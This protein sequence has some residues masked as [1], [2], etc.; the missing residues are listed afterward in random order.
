MTQSKVG[1]ERTHIDARFSGKKKIKEL[2]IDTQRNFILL[3]NLSYIS[4]LSSL[5]FSNVVL[6]FETIEKVPRN[7]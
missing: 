3:F 5:M 7:T 1:E 4:F 6:H 2:N